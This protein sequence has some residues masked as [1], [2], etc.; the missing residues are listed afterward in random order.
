MEEKH[1]LRFSLAGSVLSLVA[2]YVFISLVSPESIGICGI[3]GDNLGSLVTVR[4]NASGV[5]HADGNVFF[6]LT[7]GTCEIRIVLWKD[8]SDALV[9][10]GF[11]TSEIREDSRLVVTGVLES[12]G[13]VLQVVPVRP[14]VSS[15]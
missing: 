13:G 10:K 7:D 11:D 12:S 3:G 6:T 5:V 2:L 9:M 8:I 4:G 15:G 1:L 14:S